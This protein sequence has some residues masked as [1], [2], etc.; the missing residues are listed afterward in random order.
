MSKRGFIARYNLIVKK[1]SAKSF[2]TFEEIE[3][4]ISQQV[5]F[6]QMNDD[7]LFVGF[8]LRTFQ[9]DVKEINKL[10][11]V[12]I[13]YSKSQKGYFISNSANENLNLQRM[14][15]SF[16]MLNAMN[17]S[18]NLSPY[19]HLEN[20]KSKGVENMY[21][22]IHAIK[23]RCKVEFIYSKFWG[24]NP[25]KKRTLEP[26]ALKEVKNLWYLLGK[27][28][29]DDKIKSFAL[30]RLTDLT[31]TNKIFKYPTDYDVAKEFEFCFGIMSPDGDEPKE[32]ILSFQSFRGNYIKAMPLHHTQQILMDNKKE[33]RIKLKLC[34]KP[35]FVNEIISFGEN[36][37]VIAPK[38]LIKEIKTIHQKAFKQY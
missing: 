36:V 31:I 38:E 37:K 14:M 2:S 34:I 13:E 20:R 11:G 30:D 8:S 28:L 3:K 5:E 17:L 12:E 23:N 6:M 1:L 22:L 7:D 26:Y 24:D 10:F 33:L 16:D 19:I 27:D 15:E 18:K 25:V 21:G 9:R 4:Y 29:Q 35:D 32:I